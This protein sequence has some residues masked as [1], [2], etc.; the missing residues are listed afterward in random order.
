MFVM[1][2]CHSDMHYKLVLGPISAVTYCMTKQFVETPYR[3]HISTLLKGMLWVGMTFLD[4]QCRAGTKRQRGP[5]HVLLP[6]YLA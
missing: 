5:W 6:V 4:E 3:H 2:L 1:L